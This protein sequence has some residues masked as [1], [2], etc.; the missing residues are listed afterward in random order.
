MRISDWSSDV[1]SSDLISIGLKGI[2]RASVPNEQYRH[3]AHFSYP[4]AKRRKSYL[5]DHGRFIVPRWANCYGAGSF[6]YFLGA[7]DLS[8]C[9]T[10]VARLWICQESTM[11]NNR[12]H[13]S[14]KQDQFHAPPGPPPTRQKDVEG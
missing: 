6:R 3:F 10:V 4:F 1:C 12:D 11:S 7:L 2:H 9:V 13:P 5:Q 8:R 14:A